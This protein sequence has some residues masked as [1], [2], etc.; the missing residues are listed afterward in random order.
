M[1]KWLQRL[2]DSDNTKDKY[3]VPLNITPSKPTKA[4]LYPFVGAENREIEK[5]NISD[6][7][8]SNQEHSERKINSLRLHDDRVFVRQTLIGIYGSKRL[9]L[10]NEYLAQWQ[11]G[12]KEELNEIKKDNAGRLRAN[13]WLRDEI[14]EESY[15]KRNI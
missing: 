11:E 9:A 4:L 8:P 3:P 5:N 2:Q 15:T 13:I 10:I 1:G 14:N 6:D 7:K 12:S